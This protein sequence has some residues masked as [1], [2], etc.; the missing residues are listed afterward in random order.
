M[1]AYDVTPTGASGAD[2]RDGQIQRNERPRVGSR[3]PAGHGG[4]PTDWQ[5]LPDLDEMLGRAQDTARGI[6]EAEEA[7]ESVRR[8]FEQAEDTEARGQLA[9]EALDQ[10]E[11]Q[12][13]LTRERRRQLD[14][15]EAKLWARR[16]RIERLLIHARGSGW[17]RARRELAQGE[18]SGGRA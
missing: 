16:N 1:R 5:A 12:L 2:E 13:S 7:L 14:R 9:A 18:T 10:V 15:V 17:W 3:A 11:R 4:G 8:R 6:F